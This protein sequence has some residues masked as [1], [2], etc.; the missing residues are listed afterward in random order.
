MNSKII[1]KILICVQFILHDLQRLPYKILSSQCTE[2][3]LKLHR[4]K[5][6]M[7][8]GFKSLTKNHDIFFFFLFQSAS[9][10]HV[11]HQ[12]HPSMSNDEIFYTD[13]VNRDHAC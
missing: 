1:I 7:G 2:L 6:K 4:F 9:T 8:L 12:N 5:K 13:M 10:V 3:R 11:S